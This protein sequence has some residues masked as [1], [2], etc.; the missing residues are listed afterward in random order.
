M[1][2]YT[3]IF[4]FWDERDFGTYFVDVAITCPTTAFFSYGALFEMQCGSG[5]K[6]Y[7]ENARS[8]R[9]GRLK[10]RTGPACLGHVRVSPTPT[11]IRV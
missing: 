7:G 9:V 8:A 5:Q 10:A 2:V 1:P 4:R 11:R 3:Q 6:I